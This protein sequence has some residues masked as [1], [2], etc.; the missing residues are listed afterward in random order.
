MCEAQIVVKSFFYLRMRSQ[1][2]LWIW[3]R[4]DS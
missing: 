2:V 4:L 3:V 1:M